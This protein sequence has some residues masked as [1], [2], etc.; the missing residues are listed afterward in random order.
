M[1]ELNKTEDCTAHIFESD[2]KK[3]SA[4]FCLK[5]FCVDSQLQICTTRE[6]PWT[7]K[8]DCKKQANSYNWGKGPSKGCDKRIILHLCV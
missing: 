4:Y 8:T 2:E 7:T 1:T 3:V 6:I 5:Y